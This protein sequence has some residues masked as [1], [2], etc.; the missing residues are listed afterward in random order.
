MQE[1]QLILGGN[2]CDR[3]ASSA[4]AAC[5]RL[6]CCLGQRGPASAQPQVHL[7]LRPAA[8][9][10]LRHRGRHLRRQAEGA[11]RR[12]AQHQPVPRRAARP[13]AGDAA[14][15]ALRRHR[16][17]HHLDGE[18]LDAGAA[19]RRVLAALHLPRQE[20]SG[21]HARR[22]GGVE[23]V[24]RHDQGLGAGRAGARPAHHGLAQHLLQEGDQVELDDSRA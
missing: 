13:G 3:S 10:R 11:E 16:L 24:P 22:S 15:A 20:A 19:G 2:V 12:Q 8:N 17:R 5:S 7:R 6:P 18:C 9:D 14:E 4:L 1:N 23:G 21:Q